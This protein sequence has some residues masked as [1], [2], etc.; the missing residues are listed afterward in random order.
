MT[1]KTF[2]VSVISW[3]FNINNYHPPHH[4]Y[5]PSLEKSS[6][7]WSGHCIR[8]LSISLCT[9]S[10]CERFSRTVQEQGSVYFTP[11]AGFR[12]IARELGRWMIERD[13]NNAHLW[14]PV[15]YDHLHPS[16]CQVTKQLRKPPAAYKYTLLIFT[17]IILKKYSKKDEHYLLNFS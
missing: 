14:G 8:Y 11:A 4:T 16:S 1:P 10:W 13:Y 17:F 7:S 15:L 9:I 5:S 3:L 12:K 6:I 2:S